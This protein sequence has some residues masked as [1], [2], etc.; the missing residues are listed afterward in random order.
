MAVAQG[1]EHPFPHAT[2]TATACHYPQAIV[3]RWTMVPAAGFLVLIFHVIFRF[4]E[5]QALK[6]EYPGTTYSY[7]YWPTIF[8]VVGY[9]AAIATIDTGGTGIVHGVGA[10]YFFICL[11]FLVD[12]LTVISW[13]MRRWDTKFMTK[14]SLVQKV[15][16]AAYMNIVWI[17]CLVR[18]ILSY[19]NPDKPNDDNIYAVIIEWNLVYGGLVWVLCFLSDFKDIYLVFSSKSNN[20]INFQIEYNMG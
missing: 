20:L 1:Q 12:N 15:V 16:V 14:S 18:I 13:Y 6:Y 8:S 7:M 9:M 19:L 2:V 3:F 11:Y 4:Y 17:Y 5:K 10:A